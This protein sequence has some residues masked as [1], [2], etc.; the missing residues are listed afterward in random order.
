[1]VSFQDANAPFAPRGMVL[2]DNILYV[3]NMQDTDSTKAGIAPNGEVD[4]YN[5]TTGQ[6]L[7]G[8]AM[9]AGYAGQF[10]P[11]AVVFGPDGNLYVSVFDS[12]NLNAGYVVRYVGGT[13]SGTV[14]A[15]NT[16][17][18][19]LHRPEGLTFGPDG[20]L[21]VTGFRASATDTDK[22]VIL[23]T[24]GAEVDSISLDAVGQPRAYGQSLL[25]GPSGHLFV[26]IVTPGAPDLGAVRSYDVVAKTFT[27]FEAPGTMDQPWYMT[28][29]RTDPAT[30]A[31]N[32]AAPLAS[33]STTVAAALTLSLSTSTATTVAPTSSGDSQA[34]SAA[35]SPSSAASVAA[36]SSS[37][38][39][40]AGAASTGTND[41]LFAAWA[42]DLLV[43]TLS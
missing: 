16:V 26:P 34:G 39:P 5:A 25:F 6:F 42:D 4:R 27:N 3:A 32:A 21:Y 19:D 33:S 41:L 20:R 11:R 24:S 17:D 1:L 43:G 9:P 38:T 7:G 40:A 15:S 14:F 28:F 23:N 29:G 12:S 2:K 10:N 37:V 31:Y 13:G 35:P 30:L 22:V 8:L 18:P 36:T